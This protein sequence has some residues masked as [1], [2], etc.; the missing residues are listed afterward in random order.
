MFAWREVCH[1]LHQIA[2]H[3]FA[4]SP[5]ERAPFLGD[6]Y[7]HLAPIFTC[8]RAHD[9]TKI[10]ESIDQPACRSRG[11]THLLRDL[12]HGQH[13]FQVERREKEKLWEGN[14][15]RGELLGEMQDEASL[16]LQNDVGKTL[17]ISAELIGSVDPDLGRGIQTG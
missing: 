6:A 5:D 14:V 3:L 11:V 12:G 4:N 13:F 8:A 1:H 7:H 2:H 10:L 9:V 17:G 15:A 16:H